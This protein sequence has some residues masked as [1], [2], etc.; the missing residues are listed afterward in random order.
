[1][2]MQTTIGNRAQSLILCTAFAGTRLIATGELPQVAARAKEAI[3]RGE[4]GSVLIFDDDSCNQIEVD[5][6][7]TVK[8]VLSRLTQTYG[9]RTR[10]DEEVPSDGE[11]PR[12]P[13]RPKLGVVGREVTLLPRHWDWL[14]DQPGGASVTIRKLVEE[15]RR[16]SEGRDRRRKAQEATYR[17]MVAMAGNLAGFEEATRILFSKEMA[18]DRLAAFKKVTR[19]WPAD[20]RSHAIRLAERSMQMFDVPSHAGTRADPSRIIQDVSRE[21]DRK[22][23]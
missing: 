19:E 5:F 6:R 18:K 8:N 22:C 9:A 10:R 16:A 17:F 15:A 1:M 14:D 11:A 21:V 3:D 12:G 4:E 23:P 20:V 7:G 2:K 13:G